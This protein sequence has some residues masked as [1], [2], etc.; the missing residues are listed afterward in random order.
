MD[1]MDEVSLEPLKVQIV[2]MP[3]DIKREIRNQA[4]V[5]GIGA[6]ITGLG[7]VLTDIAVAAMHRRRAL[8]E[9]KKIAESEA[10]PKAKA[11]TK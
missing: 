7:A 9:A 8:K 2:S 6:V 4:I 10:K 11:A 1:T 5:F 3:D